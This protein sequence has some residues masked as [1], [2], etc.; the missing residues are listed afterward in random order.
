MQRIQIT[1]P[2]VSGTLQRIA[3][4]DRGLRYFTPASPP[5]HHGLSRVCN[6]LFFDG[7]HAV[8]GRREEVR[9]IT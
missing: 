6:H 4:V 2:W 1:T 9:E 8:P 3:F 7:M 5:S